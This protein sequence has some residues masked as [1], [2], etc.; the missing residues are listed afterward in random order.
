MCSWIPVRMMSSQK[1]KE[2]KKTCLDEMIVSHI[3]HTRC[4]SAVVTVRN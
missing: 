4:S 3:S 2:T 1:R